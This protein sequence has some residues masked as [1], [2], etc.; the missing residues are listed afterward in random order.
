MIKT[1]K[2]FY[3]FQKL[4]RQTESGFDIV[5]EPLR[6]VFV[7]EKMRHLFDRLFQGK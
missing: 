2:K 7:K 3:D 6:A 5:E 1:Q 4:R